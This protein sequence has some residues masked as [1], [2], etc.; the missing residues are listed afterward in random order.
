M[1]AA[2][3]QLTSLLHQI[4]ELFEPSPEL[5]V[6]L[7]SKSE[8]LLAESDPSPSGPRVCQDTITTIR[9]WLLALLGRPE[10]DRIL[11]SHP[12]LGAKKVD[13]KHSQKEQA[14]L[15]SAMEELQ[16][17]NERYEETFPGLRYVYFVNGRDRNEIMQN[18]KFRIARGDIA[19]ERK[20]GV[21]AMCDIAS[22]RL[23]SIA[24]RT[25]D[26]AD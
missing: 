26:D 12:R 3:D 14:E 6:L 2:D 16:E 9:K 8:E 1:E 18:M 19:L 17:L 10:L 7:S 22:D 24:G 11:N 23:S 4:D 25:A 21:Y 20:E 5:H 15:S 13:S